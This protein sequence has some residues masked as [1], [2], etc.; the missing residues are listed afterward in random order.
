MISY[1]LIL[2]LVFITGIFGYTYLSSNKWKTI[3]E[4]LQDENILPEEKGK[5]MELIYHKYKYRT[6]IKAKKFKLLNKQM[7]SNIS[8]KQLGYFALTGLVDSIHNFVPTNQ[9]NFARF[10]DKYIDAKLV[11]GTNSLIYKKNLSQWYDPYWMC[12]NSELSPT[13]KKILKLKF[14]ESFNRIRTNKQIAK[15]LN[16]SEREVNKMIIDSI[17]L[18]EKKINFNHDIGNKLFLS[19]TSRYWK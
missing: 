15:I 14:S 7:T 19:K 1:I 18:I 16:N 6:Y 9:I 17:E 8:V 5:I 11:N 10:S 2:F 3:R 12:I 13:A 4:K